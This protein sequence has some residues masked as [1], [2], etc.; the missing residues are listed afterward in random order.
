MDK[1]KNIVSRLK[2]K[3]IVFDHGMSSQ[4]IVKV[5]KFYDIFFPIELKRL[6]SLGLPISDGF[7]NWRDI[8]SKN[9]Q[10]I[11]NVLNMPINGLQSDL[12]NENF[13]CDHWDPPPNDI[14]EAQRILLEHYCNAPKL[15]PIY[16]HRYMPF[17]PDKTN[18]P[19]FSIM[20]SDIIY[21]GT[22]LISYLEI[23]FGFRQ[24][25]DIKHAHF[26]Y[27]DFWSNLL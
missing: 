25:S 8:S 16:S 10:F 21:Y 22:D 14:E 19:V 15:I 17:V 6:Y 23:E 5:E 27:I 2:E 9:T 1:Y 18:L 26:Q 24:Y 13:W 11:K 20:Q 12:K 4:E 7:Y 3:G